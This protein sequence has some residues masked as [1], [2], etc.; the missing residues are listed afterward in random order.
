MY[1]DVSHLCMNHVT[2]MYQP[3][4]TYA[5]VTNMYQSCHMY[6]GAMPH[7]C[8]GHVTCMHVPCHTYACHM[9][10]WVVSHVWTWHGLATISRLLKIIGLVGKRFSLKR[11]YSATATYN[12]K[13]PTN[14][15]SPH[16]PSMS[17][18][19]RWRRCMRC[20]NLQVSFRKRATNY[21]ALLRKEPYTD[22][23]AKMVCMSV[24]CRRDLIRVNTRV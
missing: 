23:L 13:E 8:T 9:C 6:E 20:H 17:S 22:R 11:W 21:E 14:H 15:S 4:H 5:W 19:T 24:I 3:C 1:W 16:S 18:N 10:A 12:S 7:V 2:R